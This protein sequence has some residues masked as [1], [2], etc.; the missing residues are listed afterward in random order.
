[1]VRRTAAPLRYNRFRYYDPV[2]GRFLQP[3][4]I[5]FADGLNLY[6]YMGGNPINF[7]D[8]LGLFGEEEDEPADA[9]QSD[10]FTPYEGL[11]DRVRDGISPEQHDAT[12]QG[13]NN[14]VGGSE[15]LPR[16]E[17]SGIL[18]GCCREPGA[19]GHRITPLRSRLPMDSRRTPPEP[20]GIRSFPQQVRWRRTLGC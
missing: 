2:L 17:G 4:P 15:R 10:G 18:A 7:V 20:R 6:A 3:D 5:G 19:V 13:L 14:L 11:P 16:R 8:P 9:S 12:K 1:M